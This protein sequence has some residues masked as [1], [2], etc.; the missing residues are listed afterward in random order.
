MLNSFP[1]FAPYAAAF[2]TDVRRLQGQHKK[3]LYG[4]GSILNAHG[5]NEHIK[6]SELL[7]SVEAYKKI[8][9]HCLAT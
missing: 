7:E 6:V 3:Y 2:G 8:A 1:G 9:L 5:E 4:P